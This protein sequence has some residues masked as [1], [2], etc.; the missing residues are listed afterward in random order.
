MDDGVE[1]MLQAREGDTLSELASMLVGEGG[2]V[3][4][5]RARDTSSELGVGRR[6]KGD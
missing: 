4:V 3:G 1:E 5:K 6:A 2:G